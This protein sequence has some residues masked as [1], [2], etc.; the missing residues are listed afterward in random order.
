MTLFLF[1]AALSAQAAASTP[2]VDKEVTVTA[3]ARTEAADLAACLARNCPPDQ[4]IA[5]SLAL[6]IQ[7][8][9][10]GDYVAARSVLAASR[11]RN[12]RFAKD[13]PE[14]VSLLHG[15]YSRISQHLGDGDKAWMGR[16]DALSALK[17]GLA[18]DDPRVLNER[19]NLADGYL[20]ANRVDGA[21]SEYRE[22]AKLARRRGLGMIEGQAL[23]R[24]AAILTQLS[25]TETTGLRQEARAILDDLLRRREPA[26]QEFV[27]AARVLR[28]QIDGR[29]GGA[30]LEAAVAAFRPA[31]TTRSVLLLY[32]PP[33][34]F[35]TESQAR[36]ISTNVMARG[37]VENV[38]GQWIDVAFEIGEDG[39][40]GEVVIQR[41]SP[42][43]SG[44][45]AKAVTTS[46][47]GRRYAPM[48]I[49]DGTTAARLERYTYTSLYETRTGTRM[50][51]RS[52]KPILQM[53][54]LTG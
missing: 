20:F 1:A 38:D 46:I 3:R 35:N 32:A 42:H 39:K 47:A 51:S 45:W 28:T 27:T 15:T 37:A 23:L 52:A 10:D 21:L 31:G 12:R 26:F 17:A 13:Y 49:V 50:R 54:D 11:Q 44:T 25:W 43:L 9:V 24:R 4:D 14:Q 5:A 41:Q 16:L 53:V 34:V 29:K 22:V 30:S 36:D 7:T 8:F 33:I 48:K 6:A 2:P 40:V 19:L 18:A